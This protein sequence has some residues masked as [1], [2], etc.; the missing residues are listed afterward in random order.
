LDE[1]LN[2]MEEGLYR[3]ALEA[4]QLA[5]RASLAELRGE[6][7][8]DAGKAHTF[9]ARSREALA[10]ITTSKQLRSD[11]MMLREMLRVE[12][13]EQVARDQAARLVDESVA[14]MSKAQ[15]KLDSWDTVNALLLFQSAQQK[16]ERAV[17]VPPPTSSV[18]PPL[19]LSRGSQQDWF[20][21]GRPTSLLEHSSA[22]V[23]LCVYVCMCVC[24]CVCVCVYVGERRA[25][26][27]IMHRAEVEP[28]K[29]EDVMVNR[30][31][32]A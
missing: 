11:D 1:D 6:M 29:I 5:E 32:C 26:S 25:C 27:S 20:W 12:N 3:K 22:G 31:V 17:I 28:L 9:L 13:A 2:K 16:R 15:D 18:N 8:R 7:L 23:C 4:V 14:L 21:P 19:F 10:Q 30:K 24:V